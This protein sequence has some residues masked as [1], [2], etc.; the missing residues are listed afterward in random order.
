MYA[1]IRVSNDT[2]LSRLRYK[3]C[4]YTSLVCFDGRVHMTKR[5]GAPKLTAYET[6]G[7][8]GLVNSVTGTQFCHLRQFSD[9]L[10][11][12]LSTCHSNDEGRADSMSMIRST[13]V[14]DMST[15][16]SRAGVCF[17]ARGRFL[18]PIASVYARTAFA[19]RRQRARYCSCRSELLIR[20]ASPCVIVYRPSSAPS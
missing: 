3:V 18:L 15:W 7:R 16:A 10:L 9:R 2:T 19:Y 4:L 14:P 20:H 11:S 17:S 5:H 6:R 13:H 8:P 1:Q 12:H